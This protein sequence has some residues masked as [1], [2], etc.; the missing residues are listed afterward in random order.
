MV[1]LK[2]ICSD[3]SCNRPSL[4][5]G[6]CNMHYK[7][8]LKRDGRMPVPSLE[9][10]FWAK[11]ARGL[12][13]EC[14]PW[15]ASSNSWGYGRMRWKARRKAL[16]HR[17]AYE[18]LVGP[19]PEDLVL[20]HL[21]RVRLCVN[22]RHLQPVTLQEN[23]LR[24]EGPAAKQARQT[25]CLRGHPFNKANTYHAKSGRRNCRACRR[26]RKREQRS[27]L[28]VALTYMEQE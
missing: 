28:A 16:A 7:R 12:D 4:T 2:S 9:E 14:W 25:H 10:R 6:M 21:C 20:D 11:V 18:L 27:A 26:V 15:Q 8:V 17:I 23:I 24:G 13:N 19:I 3:E 5:R 22:P 1:P